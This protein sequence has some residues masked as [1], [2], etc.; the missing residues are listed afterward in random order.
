MP[1]IEIAEILEATTGGTRRHLFDLVTG[2]DPA[3]FHVTV[4]VST[5]RDPLFQGDLERMRARGIGVIDI[6]MRRA[7]R[8]WH[9][10]CAL[11]RI[12]RR[13]RQGRFDIVHTHSS[14]AGFLGRIAA[15]LANIPVIIHTP[16]V[17]PFLMA[18]PGFRNRFYAALERLAARYTTRL[19]C[20]WRDEQ[21]VAE[22]W[23]IIPPGRV[24]VIENG[25][26]GE[27]LARGQASPLDCRSRYGVKAGELAVGMIGRFTAQKGHR[28]LIQAA[29]RVCES[30][31][32]VRFLLIGDGELK[33]D[34]QR[35]IAAR[36]MA[37]QFRLLDQTD[38]IYSFYPALDLFVLPSLWEGLPYTLL[39]AM[40]FRR[41]VV[42][43]RVGGVG[44][45]ITDGVD[46]L[47]VPPAD[48]YALASAMLALLENPT[49]RAQL[50]QAATQTVAR[51]FQ[52]ATMLRHI[53]S[54]Y[55]ETWL[56]VRPAP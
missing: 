47:L 51:R 1:K 26:D 2:L 14:K 48:A 10:V 24:T 49:L 32:G 8:P 53:T 54:V 44:D 3:R 30:V 9:D 16:H 6:P 34:I 22:E 23:R 50:A 37:E 52:K 43:T 35:M 5:L 36:G 12:R 27:A 38:D 42:A 18:G 41:A 40:A 31:P 7:I 20:V 21:K 45:V 4:I 33:S 11:A 29:Q 46:G 17:F 55:E 56:A 13:L 15:R 39:E 19:I 28:F 25:I